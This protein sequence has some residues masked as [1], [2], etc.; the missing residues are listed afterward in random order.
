[1]KLY[2]WLLRLYPARFREEYAAPLERQF[3][4]EYRE[5]RGVGARAIFWL[6]AVAD[7]ATSIPAEFAREL[8]QDLKY[9]A[10]VYRR[11]LW[12]TTLAISALALAI[13]VTTGVFSVVNALLIRG[14]PFREPDRLM[15]IPNLGIRLQPNGPAS[16]DLPGNL[17]FDT[18]TYIS[19]DMNLR[20]TA[21][22]AHVR[23]TETSAGFFALLGTEPQLGRGFLTGEDVPG[24]DKLAVIGYDLWQQMFGGDPRVLG[25]TIH[26]NGVPL[27]VV[28]VAPP[29]FDYPA[30]T[31]IWTPSVFDFGLLGKDYAIF[32]HTIARLR[33]GVTVARAEGA[34]EAALAHQRRDGEKGPETRPQLTP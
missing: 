27:T 8:R 15:E 23:V 25:S 14:L 22:A 31:V 4:D 9:A 1:M 2:R 11:R 30:K 29:R 12:L 3:A 13:G 24:R 34:L 17:G 32:S 21:Q 26:V 6:R 5:T 28:G 19:T 7:L 33:P 16:L 20:L 18:A 10:R